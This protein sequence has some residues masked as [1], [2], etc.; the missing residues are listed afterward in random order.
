MTYSQA[1]VQ[2]DGTLNMPE[3]ETADDGRPD[4]TRA[5]KRASLV[6]SVCLLGFIALFVFVSYD[7]YL[8]TPLTE[9]L[10]N[11]F[12]EAAKITAF[13]L[14]YF[15]LAVLA[16]G[17]IL[18][19]RFGFQFLKSR[20]ILRV[21]FIFAAV[22]VLLDLLNPNDESQKL[23]GMPL[24]GQLTTFV[25]MVYMFAMFFIREEGF[26]LFLKRTTLAVSILVM[27][28]TVLLL[29][30]WSVGQG[31]FAFGAG[32]TLTEGDSL[33]VFAFFTVLFLSLYF[34]R[35]RQLYLLMWAANFVLILLSF[36]RSGM[37]IVIGTNLFVLLL[38]L[39]V[40]VR[41]AA[42]IR[43]LAVVAFLGMIGGLV[44]LQT[45]SED[46]TQY[47]FNRYFGM[48]MGMGQSPSSK[49]QY[50]GDSGHF[51]ES[52]S[53]IAYAFTKMEFWGYGGG[54]DARINIPGA[55]KN[56]WVHNVFAASWLYHGVYQF[57]FYALLA[58][59]MCL[60]ALKIFF[61]RK[62]HDERFVLLM[63]GLISFMIMMMI[64]WYSNPI[65]MAES[66]KLRVLW[67]TL[68]AAI[69]RITPDNFCVLFDDPVPE[70]AAG[71]QA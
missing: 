22:C 12:V 24:A 58:F 6:L 50:A 39:L 48:F 63:A 4:L 60:M 32:A 35:R 15:D 56:L 59:L 62:R 42:I 3:P 1:E 14:S 16:V 9:N 7:T 55:T 69:F 49:E 17:V 18:L 64:V 61:Q 46:T 45:V 13:Y 57:L 33:V 34:I 53:T 36:R 71:E 31:N 25:F 28:R 21:L 68:L 54:T 20:P 23:L 67:V 51:E 19:E 2:P 40:R 5:K 44:V 27:A 11:R 30:L 29:G 70:E 52:S 47:Y 38:H 66:L 41:I 37:Y 43:N 10:H 65:H 26:L 8:C